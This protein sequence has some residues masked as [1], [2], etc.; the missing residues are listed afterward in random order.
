[1]KKKINTTIG[2]FIAIAISFFS[3]EK[4]NDVSKSK[5]I[6]NYSNQLPD[7]NKTGEL[8]LVIIVAQ[9]HRAIE[10]RPRDGEYCGCV[11]C[12]GICQVRFFP[13]LLEWFRGL[14]KES[15]P[16]DPDESVVLLEFINQQNSKLYLLENREFYE[17]EFGVDIPIEI[18][19][20][21]LEGTGRTSVEINSGLYSFVNQMDTISYLGDD[22][23]SYGYILVSTTCQ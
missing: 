3:C 17:E 4:I 22:Y 1:M 23:T 21:A 12:F 15:K 16:S 6:D 14:L 19:T 11:N 10:F 2:I 13:G 5:D 9:L 7:N 8:N 18:P 20:E